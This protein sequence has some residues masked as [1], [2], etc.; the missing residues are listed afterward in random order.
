MCVVR[1]GTRQYGTRKLV[2][3]YIEIWFSKTIKL[4]IFGILRKNLNLFL[5]LSIANVG[6][7]FYLFIK[8]VWWYFFNSAEIF[9]MTKN[10]YSFIIIN[11]KIVIES[12]RTAEAAA[13]AHNRFAPIDRI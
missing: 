7:V 3:I 13:T 5:S 11:I 1:V 2:Y 6:S 4:T 10:V 8:L 12:E 9:A